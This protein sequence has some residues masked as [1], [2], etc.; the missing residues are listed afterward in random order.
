MTLI[1]RNLTLGIDE[2]EEQLLSKIGSRLRIPPSQVRQY[3]V[4]RRSLDARPR[5]GISWAY[6]VAAVLH[7]DEQRILRRYRKNDVKPLPPPEPFDQPTG[8]EPL[9]T[10]PVVVGFGSG[11]MFAALYLAQLGYKPIVLERGPAVERRCAGIARLYRHGNFDPATNLVFGEGGAGTYSDGKLYTRVNDTRTTWLLEQFVRFGADPRIVTDA[12]PHIGSDRLPAICRRIRRYIESCGGQVRFGACVDGFEVSDSH[13]TALRVDGQRY[14]TGAVILATGHSARDT[15][16][17]LREADIPILAKPFQMGVRIEHPQE[18]INSWQYGTLRQ[19]PALPPAY[20][21]LVA[22]NAAGDRDV[23]SFCM[24]PGGQILP[25][26]HEQGLIVTNGGSRSRRNGPFGNSGLV[27]TIDPDQFGNDPFA[28]LAMQ[29]QVESAAFH[30]AAN[31]YAVPAQHARDFIDGTASTGDIVTSCPTGSAACD[32]GSFLPD[33]I[34]QAVRRGIAQL[35]ERLAG[36][37]G[38]DAVVTGPESR[39]TTAVRIDRSSDTRQSPAAEG[40]YPAGEGA[41]YAGGIVS[42]AIDALR[43]AEAIVARYAPPR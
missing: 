42:S 20:Y 32:L 37:A 27:T 17:R 16:H 40:L 33:H 29:Q 4:I 19:H 25:S 21:H 12:R 22:K 5:G 1:I 38:P 36:Y 14:A 18:L 34:T 26:Q 31:S 7:A 8:S 43:S 3:G 11:G 9:D 13:L 2:P 41:G 24:C 23:F 39:A 10:P 6:T 35:D 28:G 15:Y 30:T